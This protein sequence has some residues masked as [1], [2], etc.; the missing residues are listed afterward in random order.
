MGSW[1]STLLKGCGVTVG[2]LDER[3]SDDAW[4]A[5]LKSA[6]SVIISVPIHVTCEVVRKV[7]PLLNPTSL[8]TDITS[9]KA[10]I[11][12]EM[13]THRGEVVG[14]H[15]MCAPCASGLSGQTIVWCEERGGKRSDDLAA[16]L[17]LLGGR[18]TRMD[19]VTHDR[20]MSLIQVGNHFQSIVLAHA[21]KTL[22]ITAADALSVASPIYKVRMQL[23]G[24]ILAQAP[25][26][27]VD[28]FLENPAT[29]S[30]L[31]VLEAS[32]AE[33]RSLIL[34]GQRAEA[35]EFFRA[36]ANGLGG[37][38]EVALQESNKLL[39]AVTKAS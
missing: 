31:E 33:F 37:Y 25:E 15:P 1:L 6:A 38:A 12:E 27:Y 20:L 7:V 9:I 5:E 24:R 22:G 28:I 14:L 36:A 10:P 2:G 16:L 26:L 35:I 34:N 30:M 21:A 13:R 32:T 18:L 29:A 3:S 39:D 17:T 11:L 23:M 4:N 19:G 8:L